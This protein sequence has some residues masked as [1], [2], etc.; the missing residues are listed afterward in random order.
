MHNDA[1][2]SL[3]GLNG[4]LIFVEQSFTK[5]GD[6]WDNTNLPKFVDSSE[7]VS[8]TLVGLNVLN[9]V[10]LEDI[11]PV[12][13]EMELVVKYVHLTDFGAVFL[14]ACGVSFFPQ[15]EVEQ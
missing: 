3:R 10:W 12:S 11:Y 15:G 5:S 8:D 6:C 4:V 9:E 1:L 2:S 14:E 7:S 13:P